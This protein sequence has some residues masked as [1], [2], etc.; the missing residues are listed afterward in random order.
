M[1]A[2]QVAFGVSPYSSVIP[3]PLRPTKQVVARQLSQRRGYA[4][5]CESFPERLQEHK[6]HANKA[7]KMAKVRS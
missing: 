5:E 2:L 3:F 7:A 4:W 1:T 6:F